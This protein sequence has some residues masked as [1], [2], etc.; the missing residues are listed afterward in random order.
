MVFCQR[1]PAREYSAAI[2]H[3]PDRAGAVFDKIGDGAERL[4]AV[5]VAFELDRC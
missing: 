5:V 2:D 1:S 4:N 3:G